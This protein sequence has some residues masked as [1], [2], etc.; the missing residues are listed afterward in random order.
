MSVATEQKKI[1]KMKYDRLKKP[2]TREHFFV[3]IENI[4]RPQQQEPTSSVEK[5][6]D[7]FFVIEVEETVL[8]GHAIHN[9]GGEETSN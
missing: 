8:P 3:G 5:P 9:V 2:K 7:E 1:I 6:D 4:S